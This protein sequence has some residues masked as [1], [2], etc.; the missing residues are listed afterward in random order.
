MGF[1]QSGHGNIVCTPA[2]KVASRVRAGGLTELSGI[3]AQEIAV[4]DPAHQKAGTGC[5]DGYSLP[6]V[7]GE[8]VDSDREVLVGEDFGRVAGEARSLRLIAGARLALELTS[9]ED[10]DE[11][12]VLVDHGKG[13]SSLRHERRG[14]LRKTG[15][16]LERMGR[17]LHR[18]AN[19]QSC[20]RA[21]EGG[22]VDVDAPPPQLQRVD[23]V[24]AETA[25]IAVATTTA[26]IN[27]RMIE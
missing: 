8:I 16:A 7:P 17:R 25:A 13:A 4:L 21:A 10:A 12:A 24:G 5:E 2:D 20:Q 22:P 11:H 18:L 6:I 9:L 3:R 14:D 23:R 1:P 27:G 19:P 26:S 15:V